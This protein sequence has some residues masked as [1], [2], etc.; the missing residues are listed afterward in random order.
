MRSGD[1][2][3]GMGSKHLT[4]KQRQDDA[5]KAKR[6]KKRADAKELYVGH[7]R[8][9]LGAPSPMLPPTIRFSTCVVCRFAAIVD[10]EQTSNPTSHTHPTIALLSWLVGYVGSSESEWI[11]QWVLAWLSGLHPKRPGRGL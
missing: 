1:R 7:C 8:T 2:E 3:V 9:R 10:N 6:A 5:S 11:H 4:K